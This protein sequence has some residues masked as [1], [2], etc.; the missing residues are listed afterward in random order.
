MVLRNTIDC[1]TIDVFECFSCLKRNES[2]NVETFDDYKQ[3]LILCNKI[4]NQFL[5]IVFGNIFY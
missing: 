1:N 2:N 4:K 5:F 3:R